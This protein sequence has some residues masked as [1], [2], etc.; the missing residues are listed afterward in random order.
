MFD[1][2]AFDNMKVVIEGAL[3]DLDLEG[4]IKIVDR[5]DLVNLAKMERKYEITFLYHTSNIPCSFILEGKLENLTA[6]LLSPCN[7]NLAGAE[8]M[9]R[10]E[11][12]H[13]YEGQF[14]R[15]IHD[16]L[17]SIWGKGRTIEQQI[18]YN[19]LL[20]VK[21][22]TNRITIHFNRLITEDQMDDLLSMMEY[23][24]KTADE[25]NKICSM[26]K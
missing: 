15:K 14:F 23:I 10:F 12:Y 8:M 5:N 16:V 7:P 6:E 25:L 26:I 9:L 2:T 4:R 17:S 1:P 19:P 18:S 21:K 24:E 13:N 20:P 3:Y 11:A 22:I